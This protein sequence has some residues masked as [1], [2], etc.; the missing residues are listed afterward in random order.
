MPFIEFI[1]N[2]LH[3]ENGIGLDK[4]IATKLFC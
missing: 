4:L 2:K 3:N 1:I